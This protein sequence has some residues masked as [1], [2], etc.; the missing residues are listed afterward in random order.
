MDGPQNAILGNSIDLNG[1]LGIALAD[2]GNED[3]EAPVLTS[4]ENGSTHVEGSLGSDPNT[5]FRIELFASPDC[6]D[7]GAGEGRTYLGFGNVTTNGGGS[8]DIDITVP[9][10]AAAGD[11]VT[12]TATDPDGNTSQFSNCVVVT[13]SAT[14]TPSPT[15][16]VTPTPTA[17]GSV[18]PSPTGQCDAIP[19]GSTPTGRCNADRQRLPRGLLVQ[20]DVQCDDDVDSVDALQ[21]LRDVAGLETFQEDGCPG[22]G[23]A[24]RDLRRRGLRW[25][26][27]FR[28]CAEGVAARRGAE[29]D[30]GRALSGHRRSPLDSRLDLR[31]V[32]NSRDRAIVHGDKPMTQ[33]PRTHMSAS[34]IVLLALAVSLAALIGVGA[35]D[36]KPALGATF[37]VNTVDDHDD[38]ECEATFFGSCSLREAIN[39]SNG[40]GV[41]DLIQFNIPGAQLHTIEVVQGGLPTITKPVIIDGTT[42]EAGRVAIRGEMADADLTDTNY[43]NGLTI[44][45]GGSTI[46]GVAIYE[47]SGNGIAI[48]GLGG[49]TIVDTYIGTPD[50]DAASKAVGN[51]GHGVLIDGT[52]NN[53]VGGD[54]LSDDKEPEEVPEANVISNNGQVQIWDTGKIVRDPGDGV[55]IT[56]AGAT[57]NSVLGSLIGTDDTGTADYG[58][59]RNGVAIRNGASGNAVGGSE[60]GEGNTISG[61]E[62]H[63]VHVR[64]A[65]TMSNSV[66]GNIIGL[67]SF[68]GGV[69][70]NSGDGVRFEASGNDIG[71][72]D[73]VSFTCDG[74]CNVIS[75]NTGDGIAIIDGIEPDF[76]PADANGVHGNFIGTDKLGAVDHGNGGEGVR[77][78]GAITTSVFGNLISGNS[79]NGVDIFGGGSNAVRGNVIGLEL[80]GGFA[81][82]NS[83]NGVSIDGSPGNAVGGLTAGERNV[84]SGNALAGISIEGIASTANVVSG[85]Y[86]GLDV[87]GTAARGNGGSGVEIVGAS[88]NTI[89]G[90][91]AG[92]GN[93]IS[94]NGDYGVNIVAAGPKTSAND[95]LVLGNR[96]GTDPTGIADIGNQAS[97]I[98]IAAG[99]GESASN[100]VIGGIKPGSGNLVSGNTESGVQISGVGATGNQLLANMIGTNA[101]ASAALE[102][103][104]HGVEIGDAPDNRI[105]DTVEGSPNMISGNGQ[106]GIF[107]HGVAAARNAVINNL[108]GTNAEGDDLGNE[109]DGVNIFESSNSAIGG[110]GDSSGNTIAFNG[111]RGV[112]VHGDGTGNSILRNRIYSNGNLGIDL[113]A[114]GVTANDAGD[115]DAGANGLQNF[116]VIL[117]VV[118]GSTS[119]T[120]EYNGSPKAVLRIEFF[121]SSQ[122]DP[123]GYGEGQRYLG[124][125]PI[126]TD[127]AGFAEIDVVF[128]DTVFAG[129]YLAATAT[130][131]NSNTSEFSGC[132]LVTGPVTATPTPSPTPS[133]TPTATPEPTATPTPT[134]TP[135]PAPIANGD[136]DCDGDVDT[137][138]ALAI[139]RYVAGL[140]PLLQNEPCPDVGSDIGG[141]DIFGDVGCDGVVDSVDGLRALRHT[142]GLPPLSAPVGC[143]VV[144]TT[145]AAR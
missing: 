138:D 133:P 81:L 47:F 3:Q 89:G 140:P 121:Y 44:V 42:E 141:G 19:T 126:V 52:A 22:I 56:G 15:A 115:G 85:N 93:I 57:G 45:G 65:N 24:G 5:Q 120:G 33:I 53:E 91:A 117:N 60:P 74:G 30:P 88:G 7:S 142:A 40:G 55:H 8:A 132:V 118:N 63:G 130:D 122:C 36:A 31:R 109:L 134:P 66:L 116:P 32:Y 113:G 106:T 80:V 98:H 82:G 4:A 20:G 137:V 17:T 83:E 27:R 48:S 58:N 69:I 78:N 107:I 12:A 96:I 95:N 75:G 129:D 2:G 50:G 43:V 1:A 111:Q 76:F 86:I 59:Q 136:V 11:V 49:N 125:E 67:N 131:T 103:D 14:P 119:I 38:G 77:I 124:F 87:N 39:A 139:L 51:G 102:N 99:E 79:G 35:F 13:G 101:D 34:G 61:N 46:R 26:R 21:Q 90:S 108:V 73:A 84:I 143:P 92:E 62:L 144:G 97:G 128:P 110:V 94:A 114:D 23:S 72:A 54:G 41:T 64:G 28:R 9:A 127:A 123:S 135:T 68:G 145:G 100:N 10:T 105:G 25:R 37:T 71:L 112:L 104:L 6:D 29:R 16:T 70:G 18:T